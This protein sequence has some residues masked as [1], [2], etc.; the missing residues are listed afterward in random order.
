M[1]IISWG[2]YPK[3]KSQNFKFNNI[4]KLR[5]LVKSNNDL[6]VHGNGRSY[7]DSAL[8][9]KLILSSKYNDFLNFD[10]SSGLLKLQSGVL[11]LDI[12]ETFVP[13]GWFFKVTPG[14]KFV[15]VGGAIAS[16][17]HGKNHHI[18]GSFSECI[19]SFT[20]MI[21]SGEIIRCSKK[22]NFELFKAT[23]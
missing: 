1:N 9:K 5:K 18:S 8:G 12:L 6:I 4:D 20:L 21:S 23:C 2:N 13:L 17:V 15:T 7:G 14:T 16:D 19:K 11:L 22:E 10:E 3:I